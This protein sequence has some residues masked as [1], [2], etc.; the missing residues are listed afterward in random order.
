MK[1]HP[2][3][4]ESPELHD[5]CS[6]MWHEIDAA[7]ADTKKLLKVLKIETLPPPPPKKTPRVEINRDIA[8]GFRPGGQRGGRPGGGPR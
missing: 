5:C 6:D 3:A 1:H 4:G 7:K 2:E 8:F